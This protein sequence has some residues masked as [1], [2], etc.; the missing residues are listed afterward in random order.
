MG[1]KTVDNSIK[2]QIIGLKKI[3]ALSNVQIGKNLGVSEK[4][5]RTTWKNYLESGDVANKKRSGRP[6]KF[7]ENEQNYVVRL[8]RKNPRFSVLDISR[9]INEAKDVSMS[10]MT[11]SRILRKNNLKSYTALRKPL[12]TP[13]D[14]I[15]RRRWCRER[16]HWT[17]NDWAKVIFSDESNFEVF[18]RKSQVL[19]RRYASEKFEKRMCVPRLQGGGGSIGIWGCFSAKGTGVRYIYSGRMNQY[20][21]VDVLEECLKPSVELLQNQVQDWKYQQDGA[22]SHTAKTVKAYFA[23]ND[24]DV[25]PWPARSPDL[26]P[27]ENIWSYIDKKMSNYQITSLEHLREC[28]HEEWLKVPVSMCENLINSMKRRVRA[29]HDAKGGHFKY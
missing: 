6:K 27:I 24:I 2:W 13:L 17:D 10:K 7:S 15:K 16:L 22:T 29:C 14:R 21:Y 11:I 12:L 19:V 3:G 26:N 18:N 5:V 23:E 1:S 25:M 28:L 9:S 8:A 20:I 4:C